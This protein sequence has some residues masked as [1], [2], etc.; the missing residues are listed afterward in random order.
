MEL[1]SPSKLL[2]SPLSIPISIPISNLGPS[3]HD[4]ETGSL[5]MEPA[6]AELNAA[7]KAPSASK[8]PQ[9]KKAELFT[10]L[11]YLADFG[12]LEASALEVF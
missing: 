5:H 11:F 8:R 9:I 7:A 12:L 1:T 10:P 2:I 3:G 4:G 6:E